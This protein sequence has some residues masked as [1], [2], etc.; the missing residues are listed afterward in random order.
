[1]NMHARIE[2]ESEHDKRLN[3]PQTV[4]G[5]LREWAR[6]RHLPTLNVWPPE[7]AIYAVLHS[8]GRATTGKSDGGLASLCDRQEGALSAVIRARETG[9]AIA[10]LAPVLR[11]AIEA[12]YL[13]ELK[14]RTRTT[15]AAAEKLDIPT[16][17]LYDRLTKAEKIIAHAIGLDTVYPYR[18]ASRVTV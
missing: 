9:E 13:V 1:M 4:Q 2:A 6:S 10:L 15:R 8:P 5:R 11:Q 17:T 18:I 16:M 12:V 7:S 14:E 3:G